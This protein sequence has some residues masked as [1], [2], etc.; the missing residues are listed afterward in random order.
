[1]S[2]LWRNI[3][4]DGEHWHAS[5]H[6]SARAQRCSRGSRGFV[7]VEMRING[8]WHRPPVGMRTHQTSHM[9][10]RSMSPG[11]PFGNGFSFILGP[12]K[13]EPRDRLL[14]EQNEFAALK[15][16]PL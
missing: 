6:N 10:A 5:Y 7:R 12:W 4:N 3:Y 13:L 8:L 2:V 9:W 16:L 11:V 15:Q 1:M 14:R